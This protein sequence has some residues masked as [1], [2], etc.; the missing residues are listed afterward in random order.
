MRRIGRTVALVL[1]AGAV[2]LAVGLPLGAVLFDGSGSDSRRSGSLSFLGPVVLST[3][4][5]KRNLNF[6]G[7]TV[8][9]TS[10]S[11]RFR[12]P[13]TGTVQAR[14][15]FYRDGAVV[16]TGTWRSPTYTASD[17]TYSH[18]SSLLDDGPSPDRVRAEWW[19]GKEIYPMFQ[20]C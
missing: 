6:N 14:M 13:G 1:I 17:G 12:L 3:T 11:S 2:G 20:S 8:I 19:V 7:L 16:S 10:A 5:E 15:I 9:Q 18:G 4:C